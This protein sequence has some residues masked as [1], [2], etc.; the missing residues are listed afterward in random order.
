MRRS[1]PSFAANAILWAM[2]TPSHDS[3]NDRRK[4][5]SNDLEQALALMLEACRKRARLDVLAISDEAGLL[6]AGAGPARICEELAATAPLAPSRTRRAAGFGPV[7]VQRVDLPGQAVLMS[8]MGTPAPGA[9]QLKE[10]AAGCI[11][12]LAA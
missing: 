9:E 3:W 12:I 1:W 8:G 4:H 6:V 7:L 2:S 5:R 10:A 11:R